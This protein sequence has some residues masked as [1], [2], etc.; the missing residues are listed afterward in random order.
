MT[1]LENADLYYR[2]AFAGSAYSPRVRIHN[3]QEL[4]FGEAGCVYKIGG[5]RRASDEDHFSTRKMFARR[6]EEKAVVD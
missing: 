2:R 1:N 5:E 4:L 6:R 3:C